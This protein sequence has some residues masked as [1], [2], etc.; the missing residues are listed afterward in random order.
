MRDRS[1]SR[2]ASI[3]SC[4]RLGLATTTHRVIKRPYK[5]L[6]VF[7]ST[8]TVSP[9][10]GHGPAS[11]VIVPCAANG[12]NNFTLLTTAALPQAEASPKR[13]SRSCLLLSNLV[14]VSA[15]GVAREV[16][17]LPRSRIGLGG[18]TASTVTA[19]VAGCS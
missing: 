15:H 19:A 5:L 16:P 7:D 14:R 13:V 12:T 17:V 18:A 10:D 8:R 1:L 4:H 9:N 2:V 6:V 3:A 11:E